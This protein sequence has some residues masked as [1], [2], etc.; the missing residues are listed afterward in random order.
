VV[1]ATGGDERL[2]QQGLLARQA[3]GGGVDDE[4]PQHRRQLTRHHLGDGAHGVVD[5]ASG[6]VG[7]QGGD[8]VVVRVDRSGR[9]AGP[10]RDVPD[11]DSGVAALGAQLHSGLQEL[12][13]RGFRRPSAHAGL[14]IRHCH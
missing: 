5:G 9:D 6:R 4:A 2:E 12:V 11:A 14:P 7:E 1:L 10:R 13:P 8:V 3:T